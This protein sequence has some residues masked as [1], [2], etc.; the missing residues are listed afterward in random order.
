M[1][2]IDYVFSE[3]STM[4]DWCDTPCMELTELDDTC[5]KTCEF[6]GPQ[7]E[8]WKRF[9]E[10]RWKDSAPRCPDCGGPL[11]EVRT[12]GT[13]RWRHCYSCHFEYE[14]HDGTEN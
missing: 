5:E 10:N 9:F 2:L 1:K 4:F 8:C 3:L 11:S 14:E 12:N 13:K 6:I 7:P